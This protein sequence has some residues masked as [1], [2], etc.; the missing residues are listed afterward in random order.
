MSLLQAFGYPAI[1]QLVN[2]DKKYLCVGAVFEPVL[3]SK[4]T[5]TAPFSD[6]YW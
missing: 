6:Q 2:R 4:L 1:I 3:V 5:S